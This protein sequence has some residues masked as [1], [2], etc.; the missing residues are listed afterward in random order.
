MSTTLLDLEDLLG[1]DEPANSRSLGN[2][3]GQEIAKEA[4]ALDKLDDL[5]T[6]TQP[7][8]EGTSA[9]GVKDARVGK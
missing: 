3:Q 6:S 2:E 1:S 4:A 8:P 5:V 7:F 9:G